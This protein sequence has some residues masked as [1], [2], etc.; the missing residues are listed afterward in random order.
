MVVSV[1]SWVANEGGKHLVLVGEL[2]KDFASE[3]IVQGY[4]LFLPAN[5]NFVFRGNL[6]KVFSEV[7][8]PEGKS[9]TQGTG[10]FVRLSVLT[11]RFGVLNVL[12]PTVYHCSVHQVYMSP[13]RMNVNLVTC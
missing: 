6:Q 9:L 2:F 12:Q 4:V 8:H 5:N 3:V 7:L 13:I 1:R 11:S 10:L